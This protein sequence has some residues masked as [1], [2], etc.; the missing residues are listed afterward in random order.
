M[1]GWQANRK[2]TCASP[3]AF[4][5]MPEN[6]IP[7]RFTL[8]AVGYLFYCCLRVFATMVSMVS[9]FSDTHVS[10]LKEFALP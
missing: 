7:N 8:V 4:R 10:V 6:E 5:A 9:P 3:A 2:R 1:H